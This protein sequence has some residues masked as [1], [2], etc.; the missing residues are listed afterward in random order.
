MAIDPDFIDYYELLEVSPNASA[1]TVERIF[2][3]LAKRHHPDS[4]DHGDAKTFSQLVEAYE[5]LSDPAA[6]AEYDAD[7][8]HQR[9]QNAALLQETGNLSSDAADRQRILSLF[10]A[11][12]RRNLKTPGIGTGTLESMMGLPVEVLYFHLWFF[13]QKKWIMREESG[14]LSITAEGVEKVE[15]MMQE[16]QNSGLKRITQAGEE[17]AAVPVIPQTTPAAEAA[18]V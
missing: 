16:Q 17:P 3:Y 7:Y 1:A 4:S 2:R 10:Y 5:T 18:T 13:Q 12:R 9:N 6:R 14:Q 11:Q 8:D 15:A